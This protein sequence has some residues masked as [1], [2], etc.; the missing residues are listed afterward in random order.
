MKNIKSFETFNESIRDQMK[1]KSKGQIKKIKKKPIQNK[2]G[3][4]RWIFNWKEG[5]GNDVW[6]K[7][8]T[9]AKKLAIEMGYPSWM[10]DNPYSKKTLN[11]IKEEFG[12]KGYRYCK[13]KA[14]EAKDDQLGW[15]N[16][17]HPNI[18]TLRKET[19]GT[20]GDHDRAM[21]MLAN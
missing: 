7:T 4:Y 11:D 20:K 8:K 9:E 16:G 10:P 21:D 1:P 19:I 18:D 12:L 2:D 5:G 6:A 13:K 17:I 15:N 14:P 3:E